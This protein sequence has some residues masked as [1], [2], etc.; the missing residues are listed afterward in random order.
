VDFLRPP[1]G[2]ARTADPDLVA[3]GPGSAPE[4]LSDSSHR[5]HAMSY[6]EELAA[7]VRRELVGQ[8]DEV[9]ERRMF[10]GICFMVG[11]AMCCGVLR[12]ELIVRVGADGH[13]DALA[14]PHTR[15]FDFTGRPSTGMVYVAPEA[16][17]TQTELRQWVEK[18]LGFAATVRSG[19]SR[20]G[21]RR[22]TRE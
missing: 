1:R 18:G 2:A 5:S 8:P 13:E 14:Q 11:G 21:R 3:A 16:V 6:D 17:R 12:D 22:R 4:A 9:V 7:R 15:V 10:G 19:A 20:A